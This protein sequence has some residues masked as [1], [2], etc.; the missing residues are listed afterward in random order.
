MST[1]LEF[2]D[3]QDAF[4]KAQILK[5]ED[6]LSDAKKLLRKILIM[7]PD[8]SEARLL[9]TEI[10]KEEIETLMDNIKSSRPYQKEKIEKIDPEEVLSDLE[11]NLNANLRDV[12]PRV[13]PDL[14]KTDEEYEIFVQAVLGLYNKYDPRDLLDLSVAFMEMGLV[15]PALQIL[16]LVG[17]NPEYHNASITMSCRA[18]LIAGKP[19]EAI[20]RLEPLMKEANVDE[21]QSCDLFYLM[22]KSFEM[23]SDQ[24]RSLEFYRKVYR[25]NPRYRDV[26]EKIK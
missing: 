21:N 10:Q 1:E 13:V 24:P 23:L 8:H 26:M 12:H 5:N 15:E 16:K 17:K 22:A 6:M 18:L 3:V 2:T 9:L 11:K 14:F 7:D 19:F 4:C 25:L 20:V